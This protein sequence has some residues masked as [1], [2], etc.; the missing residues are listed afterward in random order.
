M[1]VS[2]DTYILLLQGK[3]ELPSGATRRLVVSPSILFEL[4]NPLEYAVLRLIWA[5]IVR[6]WHDD[7]DLRLSATR[8]RIV[9][10]EV[11]QTLKEANSRPSRSDCSDLIARI[12]LIRHQLV[13]FQAKNLF[14][15]SL[16][17]K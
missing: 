12:K 9:L 14:I 16:V 10:R 6:C 13:N 7:P 4:D 17:N 5:V 15:F 1:G 11:M 8:V 2:A 3:L